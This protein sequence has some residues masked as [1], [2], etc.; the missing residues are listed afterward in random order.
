LEHSTVCDVAHFSFA[1]G[2]YHAARLEV[3]RFF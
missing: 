2:S 3:L 1:D